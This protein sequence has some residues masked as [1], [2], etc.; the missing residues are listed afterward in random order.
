MEDPHGGQ[1]VEFA[2]PP[3]EMAR[4][5]VVL[6]HGRGAEAAGMLSLADTFGLD[7]VAYRAPQAHGFTWYPNSFLAPVS[8]NEPWLS[9]AIRAVSAAV[10]DLE[11]AGVPADKIVLVGFSQGACLALETAARDPRRLGGVVAFS[12]G[13][14]GSGQK[15]G[16]V[17]PDDKVFEYEGSFDGTPIFIGC[18]DVDSHIPVS[19]VHKSSD[20]LRGLG[21]EVTERIYPGMG[22]TVND[23]EIAFVRS[24]LHSL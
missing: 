9:S 6:V 1:D 8:S 24:L 14:I 22:H 12:G 17:P 15:P 19:R 7:D 3:P 10:R 11:H 2:G 21:A 23:D 16:G 13:L 5:G 4:G 18:S 20:V